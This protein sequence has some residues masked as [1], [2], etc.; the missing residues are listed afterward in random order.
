MKPGSLRRTAAWGL[1]L[2]LVL[3]LVLVL[4]VAVATPAAAQAASLTRPNIVVLVADDWGFSDLD[5]FG[6]EINIPPLDALAQQGMRF[7]NFQVAASCSPTRS[8]LL[9]GVD[10]HRNGV[11]N[12][13]EA[14]PREHLGQPGYGGSLAT[15]VVTVAELLQASGYRRDVTGKWNVGSE[16]HNLPNRRGVDRSIVQ[17]DTGSDNWEPDRLYLPHRPQVVWFENGLKAVL[18]RDSHPSAYFVDRMLEY[19]RADAAS[20]EPIFAYL[21]F[22]ANP[23]PVQ[24]PQVFIDKCK[25]R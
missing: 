21:G 13:R 16:P 2:M 22:Q 25:G 20:G 4:G 5:A 3:V 12:L 8:M 9:T 1:S 15:N 7:A 14:M 23:V 19:L 6:G 24:A 18:P 10:N 11:G 17:G